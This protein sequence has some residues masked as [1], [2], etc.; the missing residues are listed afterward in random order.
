MYGYTLDANETRAHRAHTLRAAACMPCQTIY[1]HGS[2]HECTSIIM[3]SGSRQDE[4]K[5]ED[6]IEDQDQD[7]NNVLLE[8]TS[9]L[10]RP[11]VLHVYK[12][13]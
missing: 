8:V 12:C 4:Y 6:Q 2:L 9:E 11:A 10:N 1:G 7:E 13:T 5:D 3:L